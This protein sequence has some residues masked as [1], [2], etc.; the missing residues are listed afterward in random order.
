MSKRKGKKGEHMNCA[1]EI[2]RYRDG[3]VEIMPT[4]VVRQK[5]PRF[6][7]VWRWR[8]PAQWGAAVDLTHRDPRVADAQVEVARTTAFRGDGA[9]QNRRKIY[10]ALV[11]HRWL[12]ATAAGDG[13][14]A[15]CVTIVA[16]ESMAKSKAVALYQGI[17]FTFLG[18][19]SLRGR[20][21]IQ[22]SRLASFLSGTWPM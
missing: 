22:P 16:F 12:P 21:R 14:K 3:G 17:H 1:H 5:P 9:M 10:V 13:P 18:S 4:A 15:K 7:A 11:Q 8:G 6:Q 2:E 19:M 20:N